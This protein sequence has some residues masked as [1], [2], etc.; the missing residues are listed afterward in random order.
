MDIHEVR[1]EAIQKEILAYQEM[2]EASMNA[3]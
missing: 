3:W 2:M 1:T